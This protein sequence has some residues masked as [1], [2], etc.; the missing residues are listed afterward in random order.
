MRLSWLYR[1]SLW[2]RRPPSARRV[3]LVFSVIALALIIA[4]L[5]AADLWPDALTAQRM[6]P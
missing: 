2:A 5:E 4:G 1:M 3:I 6:K